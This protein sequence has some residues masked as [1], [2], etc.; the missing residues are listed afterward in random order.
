MLGEIAC[1]QFNLV[2]AETSPL[3]VGTVGGIL[4][5]FVTEVGCLSLS[6]RLALL[7]VKVV[8]GRMYVSNSV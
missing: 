2:G 6:A 4:W 5:L 7:G 8:G 3:V 1:L